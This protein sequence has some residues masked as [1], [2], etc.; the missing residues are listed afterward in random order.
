[1]TDFVRQDKLAAERSE[2]GST[3]PVTRT[4]QK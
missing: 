3:C 1:M 4:K 2:A